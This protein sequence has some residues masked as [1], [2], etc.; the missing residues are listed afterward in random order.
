MIEISSDQPEGIFEFSA[1][2][3]VT[4]DDY[5]NVLIPAMDKAF[6]EF[7][8]VRVLA[9]FGP[10]FE[11]YEL[12]ALVDDAKLG[13][14]H[15]QAFERVAMVSDVGWMRHLVTGFG[16]AMPCPVQ[17]FKNDEID[18]ARRWLRESLGSIHLH[19]DDANDTVRVQLLG[20][21]EPSAYAGVNEELDRWLST[22]DRMRLVLDLREFDGWQGLGGL[23]EHLE[24]VREYRRRPERVAVVGE[25]AWQRL[26][27]PVM[28]KFI[29]AEVKYFPS[30]DFE[31]ASTW[32][33]G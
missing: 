33:N 4:G 18:E 27:A 9:H 10:G 14:R 19:Y 1:S 25:A 15:C 3:K 11:G 28:S 26:A 7:G 13:L 31:A 8:R 20:K 23:G 17:S 5:E 21:L 22:R 30:A 24:L 12:G 6:E 16:F 29:R 2:G 32:V